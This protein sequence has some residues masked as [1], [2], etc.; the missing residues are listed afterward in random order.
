VHDI[1][2]VYIASAVLLQANLMVMVCLVACWS[3]RMQHLSCWRQQCGLG[4]DN[5]TLQQQ[6]QQQQQQETQW[7]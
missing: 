5:A 1:E 4:R 3:S 2:F 6:Q 7:Q